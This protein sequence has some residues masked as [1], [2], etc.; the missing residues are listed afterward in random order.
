M[1]R[2][3]VMVFIGIALLNI[4]GT[5]MLVLTFTEGNDAIKRIHIQLTTNQTFTDQLTCSDLK[6][7][8]TLIK[9]NF[10]FD[11]SQL[12]KDTKNLELE[13]NCH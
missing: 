6:G 4:T 11:V 7:N 2:D 12:E 13:K 5:V 1:K 9:A 8:E 3:N 10:M